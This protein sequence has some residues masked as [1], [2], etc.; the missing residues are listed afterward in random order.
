MIQILAAILL[1]ILIP[2]NNSSSVST[3][4]NLKISKVKLLFKKLGLKQATRQE[5]LLIHEI[6]SYWKKTCKHF[7]RL[8][9]FSD[10][11]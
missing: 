8:K 4:I 5:H 11:N 6:D 1:T 2:L 7:L 9:S 10:F 3:V